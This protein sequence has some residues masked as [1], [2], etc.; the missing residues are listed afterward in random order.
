MCVCGG[1]NNKGQEGHT[2]FAFTLPSCVEF[3]AIIGSTCWAIHWSWDSHRYFAQ[4]CVAAGGRSRAGTRGRGGQPPLCA[5]SGRTPPAISA[6]GRG[7]APLFRF[8]ALGRRCRALAGAVC[9][10]AVGHDGLYHG[11]RGSSA[12]RQGRCACDAPQHRA[13]VTRKVVRRAAPLLR[14][15]TVCFHCSKLKL[16]QLEPSP[17]VPSGSGKLADHRIRRATSG[18][19]RQGRRRRGRRG[20]LSHGRHCNAARG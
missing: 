13:S 5:L 11:R 4:R 1:R 10:G 12:P 14:V 6:L 3:D 2:P 20:S 18:R 19:E 15:F 9:G 16:V 17:F 7:T 8:C